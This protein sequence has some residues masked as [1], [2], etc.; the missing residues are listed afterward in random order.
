[1]L[2]SCSAGIDA[3]PFQPARHAVPVDAEA[4][5]DCALIPALKGEQ[6]FNR[7]ALQLIEYQFDG[8]LFYGPVCYV[9]EHVVDF[10]GCP[11]AHIR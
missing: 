7:L 4:P 6:A 11:F 10:N 3:V 8:I 2:G 9:L 1:M 5:R